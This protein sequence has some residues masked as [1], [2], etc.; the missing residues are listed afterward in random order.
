MV[1]LF[2][3]RAGLLPERRNDGDGVMGLRG[4]RGFASV[5][6]MSTAPISMVL[7]VALATS[8]LAGCDDAPARNGAPVQDVD[9]RWSQI[10]LGRSVS[11]HAPEHWNAEVWFAE[12]SG[13]D[14]ATVRDAMGIL[15][16]PGPGCTL[17]PSD[18]QH[19]ALESLRFRAMG[20]AQLSD[21]QQQ[22]SLLQ[23]RALSVRSDAISGV[24]YRGQAPNLD[25]AHLQL[26]VHD[27]FSAHPTRLR[28]ETPS[29]LGLVELNGESAEGEVMEL[30][31]DEDLQ[32]RI[33][34][35]AAVAF[36][37]LS[38][39]GDTSASRLVCRVVG[40]ELTLT[41]SQLD[42]LAPSTSALQL[43]LVLRNETQLTRDG[44][45]VGNANVDLYDRVT[46]IRST[47]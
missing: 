38:S 40:D 8:L 41:A 4:F 26:E 14:V 15:P 47:N 33:D 24:V 46:L 19:Y 20:S 16:T 21:D 1:A 31:N 39:T 27:S 5:A 34:S 9:T 25:S 28:F 18:F 42:S 36:V 29:G 7:R 2:Y 12:F 6:A 44:S 43:Q 30:S 22:T 17:I 3:G 23:P 10:Q 45:I 32:L 11:R 35:D 13:A 37:V